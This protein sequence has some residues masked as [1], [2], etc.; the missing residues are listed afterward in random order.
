MHGRRGAVRP[1]RGSDA[2]RHDVALPELP[3]GQGEQ[4]PMTNSKGKAWFTLDWNP[5]T[6]ALHGEGNVSAMEAIALLEMEKFAL[7]RQMARGEG[8]GAVAETVLQG[9]ALQVRRADH[10]D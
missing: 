7:I 2:A 1:R 5:Q 10:L 4:G 9:P 3:P 8:A 6:G